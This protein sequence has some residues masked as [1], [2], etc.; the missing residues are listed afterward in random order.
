MLATRTA[1]LEWLG[2]QAEIVAAA[3]A[4]RAEDMAAATQRTARKTDITRADGKLAGTASV[5][6]NGD[7]GPDGK[8]EV[9]TCASRKLLYCNDT[10]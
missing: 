9:K 3:A 1:Y 10:R 8:I 2:P 4:S 6:K 5:E 7:D